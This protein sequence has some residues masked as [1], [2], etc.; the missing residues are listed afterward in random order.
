METRSTNGNVELREDG[1][2]QQIVGLAAVFYRSD[3][4]G[5]EYSLYDD[6]NER[7][8]A[9]AFDRALAEKHDVRALFNHDANIV[10][11]RST[12]GTLTLEKTK[13]GLP[14]TIDPPDT[15]QARD[16]ITMMK[17]G[18]VSGSSFSF[19]AKDVSWREQDSLLIREVRDVDLYDVCPVTYPAYKSSTSGV[20]SD[21]KMLLNEA[22]QYIER[23]KRPDK[24][25]YA[26][27]LLVAKSKSV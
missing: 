8:M 23:H 17:R 25:H 22:D 14:Y 6:I 19:L 21:R 16:I 7:I 20:R 1:D 18:D 15:Q 9:T 13:R 24:R 10:L 27:R 5:T 26:A 2:V 12:S 11:G 3:D 4:P